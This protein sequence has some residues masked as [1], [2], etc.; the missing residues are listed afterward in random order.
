MMDLMRRLRIA[1]G[2]LAACT[3]AAAARADQAVLDQGTLARIGKAGE[4]RLAYRADAAPFSFVKDG[5][6]A[7]YSV[8][9]CRIV[10][11][12]LK[13]EL[14]LAELKVTYVEV[15]AAD[16]FAAL[17]EDRADLLCEATTATLARRAT[18]DF[19]IP[20]Y[21][22]GAGMV[23]RPDGPT[24][25]EAFAGR[26]LGVLGGTTTERDIKA[27]LEGQ[28]IQAELKVARSHDEG[29][30]WLRAGEVSAYFGDRAILEERLRAETAAG[31]L[32]LADDYLTIEPYGLAMRID[33]VFRLA[34]DRALSRL[35]RSGGM[36]K[37][38]RKTV[39]PQAKPSDL[40]KALSR[41]SGLPE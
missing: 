14:Q 8:E 38:F 21:V 18:M 10:A 29:L 12:A 5:A 16:R 4:I 24:S 9:L 32:F 6:P 33:P 19:S 39:D 3:I 11:E 35:F 25:V 30:A 26:K 41:M 40:L 22:S 37:V 34:V 23:I 17:T 15:G 31:N 28:G 36:I 13:A 27:L 2:L 20:T 7:G 1:A